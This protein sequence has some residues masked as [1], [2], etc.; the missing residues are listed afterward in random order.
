MS[1]TFLCSICGCETL[2]DERHIFDGRQLCDNRFEDETVI[3]NCCE[4]RVWRSELLRSAVNMGYRS[5]QTGT[6]CLHVHVNRDSPGDTPARQKDTIA[7]V[8]FFVE[9]NWNEL[10]K[11]SR[12]TVSRMQQWAARYGRKDSPKEVMETAKN[13]CYSR[14]SCV[15]LLNYN[16]I[17]FRMFRGTLRCS[18]LKATL[19]LVNEICE[20]QYQRPKTK[21]ET[22]SYVAVQLIDR[23]GRLDFRSL[24]K[25]A[26][27]ITRKPQKGIN[28]TSH[29][30]EEL[31]YNSLS[32]QR[33]GRP[34]M[35]KNTR[36]LLLYSKLIQ[37]ESVNKLTF[38][39]E[40]DSHPPLL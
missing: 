20:V 14:Y 29:S 9:N 25:M 22:D 12:R 15:N 19:Q 27:V 13:K 5:H 38:C 10:L 16:V 30:V 37:G 11:F 1:E 32:N 18:T 2:L 33:N 7:R 28:T 31:C 40:T 17:E 39:M 34:P 4:N 36:L 26:D 21:I 6:C 24:R 35:D 23:E 3:C 8:L